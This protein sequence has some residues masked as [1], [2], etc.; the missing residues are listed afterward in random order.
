MIGKIISHKARNHYKMYFIVPQ[1][2]KPAKTNKLASYLAGESFC[3]VLILFLP[4]L[5]F[6]VVKRVSD[7][8]AVIKFD[9]P[10][11]SLNR[12]M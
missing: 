4:T 1:V 8:N 12:L 3:I 5:C 10:T 11:D 7:L 2:L 6:V 9:D